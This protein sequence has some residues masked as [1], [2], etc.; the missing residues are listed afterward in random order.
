VELVE[1]VEL[2]PL[3]LQVRQENVAEQEVAVLSL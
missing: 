1:L 2:R 3:Q